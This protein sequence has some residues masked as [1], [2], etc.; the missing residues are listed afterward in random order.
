[1]PNSQGIN[2]AKSDP[3]SYGKVCQ[4][5]IQR[6]LLQCCSS[7]M[8]LTFCKKERRGESPYNGHIFSSSVIT[9]ELKVSANSAIY[10]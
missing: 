6:I 4:A 2:R 9:D 10:T 3:V 7:T 8:N 1:M 5:F